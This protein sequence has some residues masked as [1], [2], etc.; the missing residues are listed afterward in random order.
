MIE[1]E[2]ECGLWLRGLMR[3]LKALAIFSLSSSSLLVLG[4]GMGT[5]IGYLISVKNDVQISFNDEEWRDAT[6]LFELAQPIEIEPG[7]GELSKA[8]LINPGDRVKTGESSAA[9]VKSLDHSMHE[10]GEF[11]TI[12][13]GERSGVSSRKRYTLLDGLIYFF[14][15]RD[16]EGTEYSTDV[17]TAAIKGTEFVMEKTDTGEVSIYLVEGEIDLE[18][19]AQS[20]TMYSPDRVSQGQD[21][22]VARVSLDGE[23]EISGDVQFGTPVE[24]FAYYPTVLVLEDLSF[25]ENIPEELAKSIFEYERGDFR[26]AARYLLVSNRLIEGENVYR[27][28]LA[29]SGGRV[30]KARQLLDSESERFRSLGSAISELID[31]V[32]DANELSK[33]T[34]VP[35]S[36]SAWI[37][38]S[39]TLQAAGRLEAAL[40][41]VLKANNLSNRM[42]GVG[43]ARESEILF[44]LGRYDKALEVADSALEASPLSSRAR[45]T[46]AFLNAV[47]GNDSIALASFQEIIEA[48]PDFAEAYLGRGLMRIRSGNLDSGQSDLEV[49]TALSPLR[50]SFRTYL[51]R[52]FVDQL[53]WDRA[54][55]EIALAK[56][57]NAGDPNVSLVSGILN[58]SENRMSTAISDI[59]KSI[60]SGDDQSVH[61][62]R[63]MLREDEALRR[64]NLA[65]IYS[66][67]ALEPLA[68]RE[69][70]LASNRNPG[71]FSTRKHLAQAYAAL[72][73]PSTATLRFQSPARAEQLGF[74]IYAPARSGF[75]PFSTSPNNYHNL[76]SPPAEAIESRIQGFANHGFN[77]D[78]RWSRSREDYSVSLAGSWDYSDKLSDGWNFD[79]RA[80]ELGL[81]RDLSH[82]LTITG[83]YRDVR[84]ES[85]DPSLSSSAKTLDTIEDLP[86][87]LIAARKRW[88][89]NAE[90]AV[91]IQTVSHDQKIETTGSA[92]VTDR[93]GERILGLVEGKILSE[94]NSDAL[95]FEAQHHQRLGDHEV[96]AGLRVQEG[97]WRTLFELTDSP[98]LVGSGQ[99]SVRFDVDQ[100]FDRIE[101]YLYDYFDVSQV[102]TIIAGL[103]ITKFEYPQNAFTLPPSEGEK[104]TEKFLPKIG[105]LWNPDPELLLRA[106]YSESLGGLA[107]DDGYRLEPTQVA[108]FL[109]GYRTLLAEAL[110]G[111]HPAAEFEHLG[112]GAMREFGE[113]L[114][115]DLEYTSRKSISDRGVGRLFSESEIL[116]GNWF[117]DTKFRERIVEATVS[118]IFGESTTVVAGLFHNR[119]SVRSR[120]PVIRADTDRKGELSAFSARLLHRYRNGYFAAI[121]LRYIDQ[122]IEERSLLNGELIDQVEGKD[123][124]NWQSDVEF[125]WR[126]R[127]GSPRI[128]IGVKNVFDDETTIDPLTWSRVIFPGRIYFADLA[129]R[130]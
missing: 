79:R 38:R 128:S 89:P 124:V 97:D 57:L 87:L 19:S 125:G 122:E 69:A 95:Q 127:T 1:S 114:Y 41:S 21:R 82:D 30:E 76:L 52:W 116:S 58:A 29:L 84:R 5:E 72:E 23:I 100:P 18:S 109:Q 3:A 99:D 103:N 8:I 74:D 4:Q 101:A 17:V 24:W 46:K 28:A 22:N 35:D 13:F 77:S 45:A 33:K 111:S 10:L 75:L 78:M 39:Y 34:D 102:L 12:R 31:V 40:E 110:D 44:A 117:T 2:Y 67:A 56:E 27:A 107:L 96:L 118:K 108:G 32:V 53:D 55:T 73:D 106:A 113:N 62:S 123:A 71:D 63:A 68:L 120:I 14:S 59:G 64:A 50:A 70:A 60:R 54:S 6:A 25:P 61:R 126:S 83:I 80:I 86:S 85:A 9:V 104:V 15:R 112:L 94:T 7:S 26:T 51:A 16:I 42:S 115:F 36:A 43:L 121:D 20:E 81:K 11:T 90:S 47:S 48:D 65:Q 119:S 129:W 92:V 93:D 91:F 66:D 88:N 130:F 105:L 37:A 49:A 98:D